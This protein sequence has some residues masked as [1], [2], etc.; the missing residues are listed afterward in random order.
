[1][2]KSIVKPNT[3]IDLGIRHSEQIDLLRHIQ[4]KI[5]DKQTIYLKKDLSSCPKCNGKLYKSVYVRGF[6]A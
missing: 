4:Q 3:I 5:L 2:T 1:M 6:V